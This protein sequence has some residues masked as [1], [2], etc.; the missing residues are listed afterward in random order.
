MSVLFLETLGLKWLQQKNGNDYQSLHAEEEKIEDLDISD[1]A[2]PQQDDNDLGRATIPSRKPSIALRLIVAAITA[3]AI[4]LIVVSALYIQLRARTIAVPPRLD[5]G[6]SVAVARA[7]GCTF[8]QLIK[9]WLPQECPRYGLQEHL[10][11][12]TAAGNNTVINTGNRWQYYREREGIHEIRLE[13]LAE[14]T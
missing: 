13:E 10:A 2:L 8:D 9:T 5:C 12:A 1:D 14:S 11:A 4:A 6:T 7:K 3:L